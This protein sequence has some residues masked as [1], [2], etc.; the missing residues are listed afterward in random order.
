MIGS[1]KA[2]ARISQVVGGKLKVLL[3]VRTEGTTMN[4]VVIV[5]LLV[6]GAIA[7]MIGHSKD[8][9][10]F[11]SFLLGV[12][13]GVIGIVIVAVLPSGVPKA[14]PGL[15]AVRCQTCNAVQN[16]PEADTTFE[17]WQCK[18]VSNAP[19]T[20]R[21]GPEDTREWLNRMKKQP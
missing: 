6:C 9:S 7:A 5:G 19:D 15:Q 18:R 16:I 2:N 21:H 13:L 8:R 14:P 10:A 4:T 17:C 12:F 20:R 1:A 11:G 3:F